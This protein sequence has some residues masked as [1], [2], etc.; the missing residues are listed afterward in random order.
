MKKIIF[1][2][3]II[4]IA[5]GVGYRFWKSGDKPAP[6][7]ADT[8]TLRII[9]TGKVIG[10]QQDNNTHAWLGIPFAKAP[11]GE[12][13]WKAPLPAEK[14]DGTR[15]TLKAGP[16]CTQIGGL[17]SGVPKSKFGKPVGTED[18]LYMNIFAPGYTRE[19]I[20][21][22]KDR[23]PVLLWI[24]GGGNSIGHGGNYNGKMLAEKYKVIIITFNYRLGPFGW[25]THPALRGEGTTSED[26]SGNYGTLD[27]VRALSWIK[28]NISGFGGDPGNVLVFGESAGGRNT[29]NMVLSPKAKGLFHKAVVQSGSAETISMEKAENYKDETEPGHTF[30]SKEVINRLLIADKT[31]PDREA[32][33]KYQEKLSIKELGEYLRSKNNLDFLKAYKIRAAGMLS[34]PQVFRDGAVMPARESREVFKNKSSYN[35]VP[36]ILGTTR[37]EYKLF[38]A[39]DPDYTNMYF[40][41]IYRLKDE[42]LYNLVAKYRSDSWKAKGVDEIAAIM[43]KS[44]G[45]SVYAY[46]F[47]WDEEPVIL[48]SDFSVLLGAAHSFEIQFVFK[49]FKS[50]FGLEMLYTDEN[51]PGREALSNSMSSYWAEF[52]YSGSPGKGRD[53][54]ELEWKAWNN[55][56]EDSGKFIIFDTPQDRG[57]RMSPDVI[58]M[59]DLK[60][61]LVKEKG[62][63]SQ[64]KHC[65]TYVKL[66]LDTPNWDD[67]EYKTLGEKGCGSF[68]VEKFDGI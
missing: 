20:P 33:K 59:I 23:I 46:R 32:A 29:F 35:A 65:E 68:P 15:E 60:N 8:D 7:S 63:S 17:L 10:F 37:D 61:K 5:I 42:K 2:I 64:E 56:S 12:L 38:M 66:F 26:R 1:V 31:V 52:A 14:W 54:K 13:R 47:D 39:Q 36:V 45:P 24:H 43:R 51:K 50:E 49:H 27:I 21:G 28:N 22:G 3:I 4:I 58:S 19:N 30:S 48:G 16:V 11:V 6:P 18:C 57:I 62:F 44:Q 40:N 9:N 41:M 53:G 67:N 34:F 25:F 55:S